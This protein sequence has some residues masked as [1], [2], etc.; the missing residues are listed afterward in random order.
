MNLTDSPVTR[1][2]V[3]VHYGQV[4]PVQRQHVSV[5]MSQQ[6]LGG[7][8]SVPAQYI[9]KIE[10]FSQLNYSVMQCCAVMQHCTCYNLKTNKKPDK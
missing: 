7:L 5:R 4:R 10:S 9:S 3:K 6:H 8:L 2:L 1:G